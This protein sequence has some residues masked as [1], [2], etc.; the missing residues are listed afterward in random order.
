MDGRKVAQK[1]QVQAISSER[2][3]LQLMGWW[4]SCSAAP[5]PDA[6][7]VHQSLASASHSMPHNMQLCT[8][9]IVPAA[10]QHHFVIIPHQWLYICVTCIGCWSGVALPCEPA[11][12]YLLDPPAAKVRHAYMC[13]SY[14]PW[15]SQQVCMH[16]GRA[17][18][19][20]QPGR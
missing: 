3:G 6:M 20:G 19:S 14:L 10:H 15:M 11:V 5:C 7:F 9:V 16:L 4:W 1:T 13:L 17:K 18:Q 8:S 2:G 12:G